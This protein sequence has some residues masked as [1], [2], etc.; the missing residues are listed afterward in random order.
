MSRKPRTYYTLLSRFAGWLD[1]TK[2]HI[3]FGAYDRDDVE[4]ERDELR[5]KGIAKADLKIITTTDQQ[6]DIDAMV[7]E[8]NDKA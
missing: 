5:E 4:S 8:L 7:R 1:D 2:W 3:E 6:A